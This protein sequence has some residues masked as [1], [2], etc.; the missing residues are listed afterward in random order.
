MKPRSGSIWQAGQC[1]GSDRKSMSR[2][3]GAKSAKISVDSHKRP[4]R[5]IYCARWQRR[6]V[7]GS[8]GVYGRAPRAHKAENLGN[9]LERRQS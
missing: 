3:C 1:W 8:G 2:M 5:S 6:R 9:A 4:A 7:R